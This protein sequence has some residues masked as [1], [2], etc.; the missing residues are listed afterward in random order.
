MIFSMNI[1]WQLIFFSQFEQDTVLI[2]RETSWFGY[3]PDGSF[4]TVLSPNQTKLYI[5]DWIG[6]K[7]LDDAGKVKFV[8]VPGNHLGI[9]RK[10]M[11]KY[12][13][14]Y[15]VD[16]ASTKIQKSWLRSRPLGFV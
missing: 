11:K 16:Q 5:E 14:P 7:T 8:S 15:L 10:D 13:V 12:I 9:S 3:Y 6:L 1:F 4:S 2:P